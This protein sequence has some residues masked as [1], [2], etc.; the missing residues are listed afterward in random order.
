MSKQVDERVVSM[1]FDN[2]NFEKNVQTTLGSIDKLNKSLEFKDSTKGL[3]NIGLAASKVDMTPLSKGVEEVRAKFSA[4]DVVAVTTLANITN[5]AVNAGKNLVKSLSVDQLTSGW[6]KYEQKTASVQTILNATGKSMDEV[7]GYLEKLMWFSDETSYGFNDMTAAL[8]Q[9]TSSGG[10]IEKLIPLITGVANATAYAGKGATEFS[11]V[12]YN[13][14]QSY[15]AGYLQ[16]MDWRSLELAGIGSKQLKQVFIDTAVE[17]GKIEDGAVTIAN[18]GTTLKDKWADTEVM[19][20]AFGKFGAFTDAVY[21]LSQDIENGNLSAY[22]KDIQEM[23]KNGQLETTSQMIEALSEHYDELGTTAFRS[24]QEAKTFTEAI[25][26]TKDAVSSGWM[27]TFELIFG[28]YV[29]QKKLWT[30]LANGLWEVFAGGGDSRNEWLEEVMNY[31]PLV[32]FTDSLKQVSETI[33]APIKKLEEYEKA[34][35]RVMMGDFGNGPERFKKLTDAGFDWAYVQNKINEQYGCSVRYATEFTDAQAQQ[36]M[37]TEELTDAKLVDIGL[38]E[39]EI[40]MYRELEAEAKRTG[41][42]VGE[43]ADEMAG[44]DTRTLLIGSFKNIGNGILGVIR[45]IREAFADIFPAPSALKIYNLIKAFN[46][47]TSKLRLIN[48]EEDDLNETGQKLKRTFK[49]L[50]AAL[51]IILTIVGGPIKIAFKALAAI[52]R[53]FNLPI[54]DVTASV[55]D[56]IVAF[57]D[58][59]DSVLDFNKIFDFLAAA[60]KPAIDKVKEWKDAIMSME[61]VQKALSSVK[62][63][64]AGGLNLEKIQNGF[65]NIA[66]ALKPVTDAIV[67]LAKAF[68]NLKPVQSIVTSMSSMFSSIFNSV[69]NGVK[70]F[71]FNNVI[72]GISK[73][74][75]SITE[76]LTGLGDSESS[77][78]DLIAGLGGALSSGLKTVVSAVQRICEAIYNTFTGFFDINSPS[79]VMMT[80]G[81][82]IIAGLVAGLLFAKDDTKNAMA[83]VGSSLMEGLGEA[84]SKVK[85]IIVSLD[86]GKIAA[87]AGAIGMFTTVNKLIKT[88]DKFGEGVK[89]FGTL[90]SKAGNFIQA[91]TDKINPPKK[92]GFAA[93]SENILKLAGAI[94]I[95]A[96]AIYILAQLNYGKLWSAVGAI[97]VL[98]GIIYLLSLGITKLNNSPDLAADYGKL[99]LSLLGV[100]AAVMLLALAVKQLDF[101][102]FENMIPII[103]TLIVMIAGMIVAVAVLRKFAETVTI[104]DVAKAGLIFIG[105]SAAILQMSFAA[106]A[107]SKLDPGAMLRGVS[108]VVIFGALISGLIWATNLAKS[109]S[110]WTCGATIL[111]VTAAILLMC[112]AVKAVSKLDPDVMLKGATSIAIFGGIIVGLMAATRLAGGTD[113]AGVGGTLLGVGAAI[114]IM[115]VTAKILS[116]MDPAELLNGAWCIA[117]FAGIMVGLIAATKLAGSNLKGVPLTILVISLSITM[118]AAAAAVLSLINP[119]GLKRGVDAILGLCVGMALIIAATKLATKEGKDSIVAFTTT[120]AILVAGVLVLSLLDEAKLN[121]AAGTMYAMM[122]VFGLALL[123]AGLAKASIGPMI[124]LTVAIAVMT[125]AVYALAELTDVDKAIKAAASI[126]ML[127]VAAGVML[128]LTASVGKI[129]ATNAKDM[130][131]GM[132]ALTAMVVPMFAFIGVLAT[133]GCVNNAAKNILALIS[134][135]GYAAVLLLACMGIGAIMVATGGTALAAAILGIIGLTAMVIPLFAFVGVLATM[136]AV[137]NAEKNAQALVTLTSGLTVLLTA[138]M[139][140][141]AAAA[142]ALIGIAVMGKVV[143]MLYDFM[144]ELNK[145]T[146]ADDQNLKDFVDKS[147]PTLKELAAGLG[148]VVNA[149]MS[150][151]KIDKATV[152]GVVALTE[153]IK[154][155]SDTDISKDKIANFAEQI[156]PLGKALNQFDL[157]VSSIDQEKMAAAARATKLLTDAARTVPFDINHNNLS[158]FGIQ[159]TKLGQGL[160]NF[161][162]Y[163][164]GNKFEAT[165]AI[166]AAKAGKKLADVASNLPF[167]WG[168]NN[169]QKF[170]EQLGQFG[171]GLQNFYKYINTD[172]KFDGIRAVAAALAA[173]EIAKAA[174][175]IPFDIGHNNL[176]KFAEEFMYLGQGLQNLC[177]YIAGDKFDAIK[178][179]AAAKSAKEIAEAVNEIPFDIG[180]NNLKKFAEE[181]ESLGQGLQNLCTYIK[182]DKFDGEKALSAAKSAKEIAEA[183]KA[184]PGDFGNNNLILF[185]EQL[186]AKNSNGESLGQVLSN[187]SSDASGVVPETINAAATAAKDLATAAKEIAGKDVS[188]VKMTEFIEIIKGFGEGI[189][190]FAGSVAG[191]QTETL[192]SAAEATNTIL[193]AISDI[194][195]KDKDVD[196]EKVTAIAGKLKEF[197]TAIGEFATAIGSSDFEK[198]KQAAEAAQVALDAIR[199]IDEATTNSEDSYATAFK[200]IDL[201]GLGDKFKAFGDAMN[202]LV[203]SFTVDT[204]KID[205]TK[206]TEI[207]AASGKVIDAI[208]SIAADIG[209]DETGNALADVDLTDFTTKLATFGDAVSGFMTKVENVTPD[210]MSSI[211]KACQTLID[212]IVKMGS[213]DEFGAALGNGDTFKTQMTT[214]GEGITGFYE[215]V[216][217]VAASG[218]TTLATDIGKVIDAVTKVPTDFDIPDTFSDDMTALGTGISNLSSNSGTVDTEQIKSVTGAL[219]TLATTKIPAITDITSAKNAISELVELIKSFAGLNETDVANFKT[220]M[221]SL[222]TSGIQ[223]FVDAFAVPNASATSAISS[224]MASVVTTVNTYKSDSS[225]LATS[226]KSV[227][228]YCVSGFVAGITSESGLAKVTAAGTKIGNYALNAA[229]KAI[230]SNSPSKKFAELGLFSILGFAKGITDN[231]GTVDKSGSLLGARILKATQDELDIN[232]PSIVF[233]KEVGRYIV[234]GVAEG[235]D[236]DMSA[237]EAAEQKARN[238]ADAFNKEIERYDLWSEIAGK[239]FDIWRQT[240]GR[241]ATPEEIN[242]KELDAAYKQMHNAKQV[243]VLAYD[244]WQETIK[245]LG[246]NS[247]EALEAHDRYL[248]AKTEQV[249]TE[250]R[251]LELERKNID[252]QIENNKRRI[253]ANNDFVDDIDTEYDIWSKTEGRNATDAEKLDRQIADNAKEKEKIDENLGLTRENLA[254]EIEYQ[255]TLEAGSEAWLASQDRIA[256][257]ENDEL[258]YLQQQADNANERKEL[259]HDRRMTDADIKDEVIEDNKL[260]MEIRKNEQDRWLKDEGKYASPAE[261][262]ARL[263]KDER[264]NN[265]N[266]RN[267]AE[268]TW[269]KHSWLCEYQKGLEAN[270]PEWKAIAEL[271]DETYLAGQEAD[272]AVL[273]SNNTLESLF[274]GEFDQRI[275]AADSRNEVHDSEYEN[276]LAKH[277]EATDAQKDAK[278]IELLAKKNTGIIE[279][280]DAAWDKYQALYY[281]YGTDN[282][283]EVEAAY[284]EWLGYDTQYRNNRNEINDIQENALKREHERLVD[285]QELASENA[286]LRYQIWEQTDGYKA[287][288]SEKSAAKVSMLREQIVSETALLE[289]AKKEYLDAVAEHG[290]DS[291]EAAREYN[292]YLSQLLNV[293]KL[294]NEITDIQKAVIEKQELTKKNYRDYMEKYRKYY[295]ENGMT[296]EQL[297]KDA[298]LVSGYDPNAKIEPVDNMLLGINSDLNNVDSNPIQ[299]S[300]VN[301]FTTL[302]TT[303]ATAVSEGIELKTQTTID[304]SLGMVKSCIDAMTAKKDEFKNA[305]KTLIAGF[306]E[307]I[308]DGT[309]DVINEMTLLYE[310]AY[311]VMQAVGDDLSCS[312][313]IS[314]VLDLSEV[315]AGAATLSSMMGANNLAGA[316]NAS[317]GAARSTNEGAKKSD[318]E[319]TTKTVIY[320]QN[321]YSPKALSR[322]DIYRDTKTLL[323]SNKGDKK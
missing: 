309:P 195:G 208:K 305:A 222:G 169:L 294:Q 122:L 120:I 114:G 108:A 196:P 129:A 60:L 117:I 265:R 54:L 300:A 303:Y 93:V 134:I 293:S 290:K 98:A 185:S 112:I 43:L 311:S 109:S 218:F 320:N 142:A 153:F 56:A 127:M 295:L 84:V 146:T 53:S 148:E 191:V 180:H 104:K 243:S 201:T 7:N 221:T 17:M 253:E 75:D 242:T 68:W 241:N 121:K 138:L 83:E 145:L 74:I 181:F 322:K 64:F 87:I 154:T 235:I 28:T 13:L 10:N 34:I 260:A 85:D 163:I 45:S 113:L 16:F 24:A 29:D 304:A 189:A 97:A 261:I 40:E 193:A 19:E 36:I 323:S 258:H 183:A 101:I 100:A 213:N 210:K 227:G 103:S 249:K 158:N 274:M 57:R 15:G 285:M 236:S 133:L 12:M 286:E 33:E 4:L 157:M 291:N 66:T 200:D 173:K 319:A 188:K 190:T 136:S 18:F 174:S 198:A 25:D 70:S 250:N 48:S 232:S 144:I 42:S 246:E 277:P 79:K 229:K 92:K 275:D 255:S 234:Q 182:G 244:E 159:L 124:V 216:K 119:D 80:L 162:Q 273:D 279:Q 282:H 2:S 35:N 318:D 59:I 231:F 95:L 21:Q 203:T 141:G 268:E 301:G 170:G 165:K 264:E 99:A 207:A 219:E 281:K 50:F 1:Q 132:L 315:E 8:G 251:V 313:V 237:E 206:I 38:T 184:I 257:L 31:N 284:R 94:A 151:S 298:R 214:F 156:L 175:E 61:G 297:E 192:G 252:L 52:F 160:Y 67:R 287:T 194:A 11:R 179:L 102:N 187:F 20:A 125:G 172:A 111:Q 270:S 106:K 46:E 254:K 240:Y 150:S 22:P 155:I 14:N 105:F 51:D 116:T 82:Y 215:K 248:D 58:W 152:D 266:L 245:I 131:A 176:K 230:D 65:G 110:I 306:I 168:H 186:G 177:K 149:F 55:G 276:W 269:A 107:V 224:F 115:A 23:A 312:P 86:F 272:N 62:A 39:E 9:M 30:D 209:E 128:S 223:A 288:S 256:Q 32:K 271:I 310:K 37:Q 90:C 278:Q 204:S 44:A 283:P 27:K 233:N 220:N 314:P 161:Y 296:I 81:K 130:L 302:G 143:D 167:D 267:I 316:I 89:G 147:I 247:T 137:P 5:S 202:A 238:I 211:S 78:E 69:S 307:G 289:L 308:K 164:K 91:F 126:S 118:M 239:E 139:L 259:L 123:L 73:F 47:L 292:E 228:E 41:K 71:D 96:G 263:L 140:V 135:T 49:G 171:C 299:K 76:L 72:N 6:S 317:I 321:N 166:D 77:G 178:A 199:S 63:F 226:F 280:R 3:E 88:I 262:S 197:G 217:D 225:E 26:A 205:A 212:A